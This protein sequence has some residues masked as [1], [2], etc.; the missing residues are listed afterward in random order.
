M[1]TTTQEN[2]NDYTILEIF[3]FDSLVK[4]LFRFRPF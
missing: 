4:T 2:T 1:N 3:L